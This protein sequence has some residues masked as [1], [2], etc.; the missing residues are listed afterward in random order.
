M[1]NQLLLSNPFPTSLE[2]EA[3]LREQAKTFPITRL[4]YAGER[5]CLK[6]DRRT[7]GPLRMRIVKA[8]GNKKLSWA[9]YT[10]G[11]HIQVH[12]TAHEMRMFYTPAFAA[13]DKLLRVVLAQSTFTYICASWEGV[14]QFF[15]GS[16]RVPQELV[17]NRELLEKLAAHASE[18]WARNKVKHSSIAAYRHVELTKHFHGYL[19]FRA[20]VAY[21]AWRV[22]KD[23]TTIAE[24][25]GIPQSKCLIRMMLCRLCWTARRLGLE[26]FKPHHSCQH[27]VWKLD[28][29]KKAREIRKYPEPSW[30]GTIPIE[31]AV[32]RLLIT[33][34]EMLLA[35]LLAPLP[36][37][38]NG[39]KLI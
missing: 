33:P 21:Q 12:A 22:A 34:R 28:Y 18:R 9:D 3:R 31:E 11:M 14:R 25:M 27:H 38:T 7:H 17:E 26:T 36:A 2:D 6:F 20:H 32:E 8:M 1:S 24:E 35:G 13:D 15:G 29:D 16:Q 39:E 37:K 23:A 30:K 19:A 10:N 5:A 4:P